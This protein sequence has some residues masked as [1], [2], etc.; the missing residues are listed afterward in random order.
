MRY[1]S[2][3]FMTIAALI[4]MSSSSAQADFSYAFSMQTTNGDNAQLVSGYFETDETVGSG[5][6]L[7]TILSDYSITIEENGLSE[8]LTPL[9]STI[10]R[11]ASFFIVS[12][13]D[14]SL[15]SGTESF[16][17]FQVESNTDS[18]VR[19]AALR[20]G[21]DVNVFVSL[22]SGSGGLNGV[23]TAILATGINAVPEPGSLACL[24]LAV[25]GL[26]IRR[27]RI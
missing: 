1:T 2:R 10:T 13:S 7:G 21:T 20:T 8:T 26:L 17:G 27:K 3:F 18:N 25:I 15:T 24:S 4:L 6:S 23:S 5:I 19:Y 9:N 14:I 16:Q 12:P 22:N 11:D